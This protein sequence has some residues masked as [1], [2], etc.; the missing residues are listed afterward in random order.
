MLEL[1]GS[2]RGR[3]RA[4]AQG[5][6]GGAGSEEIANETMEASGGDHST[7]RPVGF[8]RDLG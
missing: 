6:C 2:A 8:L 3:A 4:D 5:R 7:T 1:N